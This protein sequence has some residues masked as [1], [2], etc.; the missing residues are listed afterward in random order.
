VCGRGDGFY[1]RKTDMRTVK[2]L[3]IMM[4][5][6]AGGC[7]STDEF[8]SRSDGYTALE[9]GSQKQY[10]VFFI[11]VNFYAPPSRP[12]VDIVPAGTHFANTNDLASIDK[13]TPPWRRLEP[14]NTIGP[15]LF[16]VVFQATKSEPVDHV[17]WIL[18]LKPLVI[19]ID[20]QSEGQQINMDFDGAVGNDGSLLIGRNQRLVTDAF[21]TR[22]IEKVCVVDP[23]N[24][25][26]ATAVQ[27]PLPAN[28]TIG[29]IFHSPPWEKAGAGTAATMPANK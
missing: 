28:P 16:D 1:F 7:A 12:A 11:D 10:D 26:P 27:I 18:S 3:A 13:A 15:V 5:L 2:L 25:P 17:R 14:D 23:W 8:R 21:M 4:L 6:L 24:R 29:D 20:A 9:N 22:H 19:G